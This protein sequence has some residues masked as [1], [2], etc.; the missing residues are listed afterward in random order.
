M[1]P[2][3][4][5]RSRTTWLVPIVVVA[6]AAALIA[7]VVGL[8]REPQDT[9]APARSESATSSSA[10]TSAQPSPTVTAQP[11]QP[12]RPDLT[13]V[14]LRDEADPL[15]VGPVDAPVG[16]I[17]F[18]DYQCQFCARWSSETMPR[19]LEHAQAGDLRI[20][21]RD[22]NVFGP[23]S[24]RAARAAYAAA[25]QGSFL[26]YHDALFAEGATR[27]EAELTEESLIALA[28]ALRLDVERFTSDLGSEQTAAQI[29]AH[30][31][32]GLSLGVTSTPVFLLGGQPIAGAQPTIVFEDAFQAALAASE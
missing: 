5:P 30:Q 27:S 31:Q 7:V 14:E 6:V 12:E 4:R 9:V 2:H 8:G 29:A 28:G 22:V 25:L 20:E 17:V 16:L 11:V 15:A 19:M 32:L 10:A 23:A 21:W 1:S 18:S 3:A 13:A 26:E 24:E